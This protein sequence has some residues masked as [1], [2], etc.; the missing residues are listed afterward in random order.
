MTGRENKLVYS[1]SVGKNYNYLIEI[2]EIGFNTLKAL[3]LLEMLKSEMSCH[4]DIVQADMEWSSV[5]KMAREV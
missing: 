3:K 4:V 1:Y 2:G 5:R